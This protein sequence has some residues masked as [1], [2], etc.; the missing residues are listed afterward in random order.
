VTVPEQIAIS[1][2]FGISE[3]HSGQE[4]ADLLQHA[5]VALYRAKNSGRNRVEIGATLTEIQ[6]S[7]VYPTHTGA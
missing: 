3:W 5:D 7:L 6:S 4:I 2:S 1:A